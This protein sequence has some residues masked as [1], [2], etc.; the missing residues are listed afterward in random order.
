[1]LRNEPKLATLI[2][3]RWT[4]DLV[5]SI[6][7]RSRELLLAEIA[8]RVHGGKH[9][10]RAA[11]G[12]L[13]AAT[14]RHVLGE[15]QAALVLEQRVEPLEHRVVGERDLV[16]EEVVAEAARDHQRPVA[17]LEEAAARRGAGAHGPH[18]AEEVGRLRVHVAVDDVER[19]ALVQRGEELQTVV[20]P[21]PVSPTSRNGSLNL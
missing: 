13:A 16:D 3:G 18:A 10:E 5:E 7:E 4:P 11:H 8:R 19:L 9:P 2:G 21:T 1:M 15:Q 20:L 6:P 17:P 14:A 12:H